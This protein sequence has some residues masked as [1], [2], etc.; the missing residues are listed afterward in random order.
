VDKNLEN[1]YDSRKQFG[2]EINAKENEVGQMFI[3]TE[4]TVL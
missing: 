3:S 1:R 4:S 2:V